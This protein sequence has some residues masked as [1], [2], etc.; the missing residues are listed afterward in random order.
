MN[1][2]LEVALVDASLGRDDVA[3]NAEYLA[4][5]AEAAEVWQAVDQGGDED[6]VREGGVPLARGGVLLRLHHLQPRHHLLL[7][8]AV[9]VSAAAALDARHHVQPDR[10]RIG[11]A[12]PHDQTQ[13]GWVRV[14]SQR[15]NESVFGE[16]PLK[17][18]EV[19]PLA[20]EHAHDP[21]VVREDVPHGEVSDGVERGQEGQLVELGRVLRCVALPRAILDAAVHRGKPV[22]EVR[23]PPRPLV[24]FP[25]AHLR[26]RPGGEGLRHTPRRH[27]AHRGVEV[28][29]FSGL[30]GNVREGEEV[31]RD[32]R[33]PVR[34]RVFVG[35]R[36][37]SRE[38]AVLADELDDDPL[39]QVADAGLH[40]LLPERRQGDA[41]Q[42][43]GAF[44]VTKFRQ[45]EQRLV[46]AVLGQVR[47]RVLVLP[48]V[49]GERGVRLQR[50]V[51]GL[52]AAAAQGGQEDDFEPARPDQ[53]LHRVVAALDRVDWQ[54]GPVLHY[55]PV[56]V[57]GQLVVF[58][59]Q[60]PKHEEL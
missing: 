9:L 57:L 45:H 26:R 2:S 8:D 38:A 31:G 23:P 36:E 17:G 19:F 48:P 10:R 42:R 34:L 32:G 46:H 40:V 28:G 60:R 15:V 13:V 51:E 14:T 4:G 52:A 55:A 53:R 54:G 6:E 37:A 49:R 35:R 43:G 12:V 22:A 20:R 5:P 25:E 7:N 30:Q 21:R 33:E 29:R 18:L 11:A 16:D 24:Q 47:G 50:R 27:P 41:E 3:T 59:V 44:F 1:T 58:L 39:A 56:R